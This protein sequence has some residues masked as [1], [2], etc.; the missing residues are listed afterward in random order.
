VDTPGPSIL[1]E[2]LPHTINVATHVLFGTLALL[3]GFLALLKRKGSVSHIRFGRYF[4]VCLSVVIATA[5]A[6]ITAFGFRAF[7]G[8][9]TLLSA[10]EGYSGYRALKIRDSGL[11][12]QDALFAIVGIAASALFLTLAPKA[13]VDWSPVVIYPTL[14]TLI[15]VALYDLV[16]FTFP[17]RWLQT[18]WIYEH[19]FKMIGS[20]TAVVSAFAGTVLVGWQ[21]F[22]QIAP[23]AIG[24]IVM[25]AFAIRTA[26]R[27]VTAGTH[28]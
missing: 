19:L 25:I 9:I 4:L 3:F 1:Q 22:S 12:L 27:G 11:A 28:A 15:A 2:T 26:M 7:L 18:T 5:I 16:R 20:Y 8:V 13:G 21:P 17:A 14:G 23:S 24:T 6:G 10:Y